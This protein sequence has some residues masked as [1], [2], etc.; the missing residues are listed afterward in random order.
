M[1]LVGWRDDF[2]VGIPA[3]DY[4]HQALIGLINELHDNLAS[5]PTKDEVTRMLGEIYAKIAAHFALE[6]LTMRERHY[7]QH[8]DHK[9][10]HE[11]LLDDLCDIMDRHE[12]DEGFNY[13][14]APAI[15][16]RDWFGIFF[17]TKD[18][19]LHKAIGQ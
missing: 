14:K 12:A 17:R 10:D 16:L 3:V 6:E 15:E 19:R 13:R 18:A 4:E 1:T 8:A 9:A 5:R 11:R 7:D 2:K